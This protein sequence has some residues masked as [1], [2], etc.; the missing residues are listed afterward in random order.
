MEVTSIHKLVVL[1]AYLLGAIPFGL[2]LS[3]L[4]GYGDIRE[5]GSGNIGATNV[6]RTGNKALALIVLLLDSGK[7]AIAVLLTAYYV[8]PEVA[9]LAGAAAFLGH[10]YPIYLKFRGG[11]GVATFFGT[12]LAINWMIGLACVLVWFGMAAIFRYSSLAGMSAAI[13]A[14][15]IAGYMG[16][17]LVMWVLVMIAAIVLLRHRENIARLVKGEEPKIGGKSDAT[18]E[19]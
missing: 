10:C 14:P 1:A 4:A 6:L 15:A 2:V 16:D 3:R 7:G 18:E 17:H 19:E 9:P 5:I 8:G 13:A 11:K 12:I